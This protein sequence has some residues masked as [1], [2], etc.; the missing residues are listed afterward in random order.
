MCIDCVFRSKTDELLQREPV[1]EDGE[2]GED[3]L[4]EQRGLLLLEAYQY[5]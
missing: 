3:Q 1:K 2:K 5:F 4:M